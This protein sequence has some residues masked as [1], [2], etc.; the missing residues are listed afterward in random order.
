MIYY[1]DNEIVIRAMTI[2][3]IDKIINGFKEQRWDK[4]RDVLELYLTEQNNGEVYIF[5]AEFD[6]VV[7]GFTALYPT[8]KEGPF[9]DKNI[10]EIS[11]F[12][13][14]TKYQRKGI[15]NKIL[16]V[17][18]KIAFDI[19][20]TKAISLGVGLH[21]GYG[22]A[23]RIYSKRGYIPD[24]SGVWYKGK[25]FDLCNLTNAFCFYTLSSIICGTLYYAVLCD[26]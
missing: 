12:N 26:P 22:A 17:A 3:D 6:N 9:I 5:I 4:P 13:V 25:Q 11:D 2:D 15:G 8:A 23:Q 7:A 24:G 18:E 16:E 10:P 21:S 14:F 1:D 19:S 20:T